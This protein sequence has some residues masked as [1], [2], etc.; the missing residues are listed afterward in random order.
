MGGVFSDEFR[1]NSADLGA[2]TAFPY[3]LHMGDMKEPLPG[4]TGT[5]TVELGR[6]ELFERIDVVVINY[7]DAIDLLEVDYADSKGYCQLGEHKVLS[8]PAGAGQAYHVA[9]IYPGRD[10]ELKIDTINRVITLKEAYQNIP[11]FPL[12][13]E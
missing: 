9:T 10:G 7:A 3:M 13:C 1:C 8:N 12:I 6:P 4:Q 2:L 11:G 5:E